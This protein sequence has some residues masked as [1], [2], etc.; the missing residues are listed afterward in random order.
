MTAPRRP[1]WAWILFLVYAA[2]CVVLGLLMLKAGATGGELML[3][4][5]W[6]VIFYLAGWGVVLGV[7]PLV[8]RYLLRRAKG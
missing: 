8:R 2:I 7:V 3:G 5:T 4:E 6:L 1:R